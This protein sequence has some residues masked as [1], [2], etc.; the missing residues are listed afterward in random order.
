MRVF[1]SVEEY[2][3]TQTQTLLLKQFKIIKM[4]TGPHISKSFSG[5][6]T[7]K[8]IIIIRKSSR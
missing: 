5:K 6:S 3:Q 4:T 7:N 8:S 2:S 1:P